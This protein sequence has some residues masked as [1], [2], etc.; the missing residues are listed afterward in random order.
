MGRPRI[1][2]VVSKDAEERTPP[3]EAGVQVL[4]AYVP[5]GTDSSSQAA[6]LKTQAAAQKPQLAQNA[7]MQPKPSDLGPANGVFRSIF[8]KIRSLFGR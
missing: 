8:S 6:G 2:S 5:A 1:V 7:P 4:E 3:D